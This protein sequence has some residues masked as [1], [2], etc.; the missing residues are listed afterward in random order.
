MFLII[1]VTTT[2]SV[3]FT[4]Q[5]YHKKNVDKNDSVVYIK[6]NLIFAYAHAYVFSTNYHPV[7]G[8]FFYNSEANSKSLPSTNS[9]FS[10]VLQY[11]SAYSSM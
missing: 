6:C 9:P 10:S 11:I 4:L 5:I 3:A 2:E 7:V 8:G 1:K